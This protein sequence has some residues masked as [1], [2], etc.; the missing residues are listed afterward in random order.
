MMRSII[1]RLLESTGL[2]R[3][4]PSP[5][6]DNSNLTVNPSDEPMMVTL[7]KSIE[8]ILETG[9]ISTKPYRSL[10]I[11]LKFTEPRW[12]VQKMLGV[13]HLSLLLW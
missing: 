10:V 8:S 11:N 6:S 1:T 9:Y 3:S 13:S 2:V 12:L 7:A 4:T 5:P